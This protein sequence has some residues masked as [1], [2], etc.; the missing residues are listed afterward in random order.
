MVAD[1]KER[2]MTTAEAIERLEYLKAR[3]QIA[4]EQELPEWIVEDVL[5]TIEAYDMAIEALRQT[6]GASDDRLCMG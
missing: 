1:G 3:M 5:N 2:E 6:E 4:L